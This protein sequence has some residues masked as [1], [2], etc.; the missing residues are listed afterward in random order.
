MTRTAVAA[1]MKYLDQALT[2]LRAIGQP[3]PRD[4]ATPAVALVMQLAHVDEARVVSICRVLQQSS[5]FNALMREQITTM[6]VSERY[7]AIAQDFDSI[8]D[9]AQRL[10]ESSTHGAP[11]MYERLG[12]LWMR[13]TRGDIA[14]RFAKI[15]RH[16]LD[17]SHDAEQQLRTQRAMLEIYADFRLAMKEAEIQAQELLALQRTRLDDAHA[18]LDRAQQTADAATTGDGATLGRL[19]LARDEAMRVVHDEDARYQIA[20]D[21]A[22]DLR[23]GYATSEA[24]MA[25]LQQTQQIRQRVH[26]RSVSFFATNETV[27]T[28]LSAAFTAQQGLHE[29]TETLNALSGGISRGVESVADLGDETLRTGLRA[30]YGPTLRADAV[31]KLVDA[32]VGFQDGALQLIDELRTQATRD[33]A[34]IADYVED[35]KR[36]YAAQARNPEHAK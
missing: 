28:A 12:Q 27:F 13:A 22:D 9:D 18:A 2:G 29:S 6:T 26:A 11:G 8:R 1:P 36:R 21:L 33:A 23:V 3:A 7:A 30:G 5:H 34:E 32:V 17:V 31:K 4:A 24:V 25:R 15:R 20:K 16:Y 14:S 19:T 35:G 10:I